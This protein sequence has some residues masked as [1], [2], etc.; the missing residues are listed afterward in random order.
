[1]KF[2]KNKD[3]AELL[4]YKDMRKQWR[5]E[6]DGDDCTNVLSWREQYDEVEVDVG[7]YTKEQWKQ[8]GSFNAQEGQEVSEEVYNEMLNGMPPESLPRNKARQAL[9]DYDIP[10]QYGFLMGEPH[11]HDKDGALYLAFGM[12][13]YGHSVNHKEP[14]YYYLGLSHKAPE[15]N[16][17]YYFFDCL[18]LLFNGDKTGLPDNFLP[19]SAF[20]DDDE[21]IDIAIDHEA[22]LYKNEYKDGERISSATLYEPRF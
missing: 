1:M 4:S 9:R 11:S 2:Y 16:G 22:T 21:A 7:V 8:D 13:D 15:I 3:T 6:Y 12:C 10:V 18:G 19:V 17:F 5:D 14:R 20:K